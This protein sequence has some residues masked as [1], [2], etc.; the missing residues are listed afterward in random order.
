MIFLINGH[1]L[2]ALL[3]RIVD[4]VAVAAVTEAAAIAGTPMMHAML[5]GVGFTAGLRLGHPAGEQDAGDQ[6]RSF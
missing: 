3:R 2:A 6:Q 1:Q 4:A 5:R